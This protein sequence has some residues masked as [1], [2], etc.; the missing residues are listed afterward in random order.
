MTAALNTNEGQ[1]LIVDTQKKPSL[2]ERFVKK[3]GRTYTVIYN[4][5]EHLWNY[6]GKIGAISRQVISASTQSATIT[7]ITSGKIVKHAPKITAALRTLSI[8]SVPFS[9]VSLKNLT[10]KLF[11]HIR[12]RDAEEL[13]LSS[14]SFSIQAADVFDSITTFVNATLSLAAKPTIAIFSTLGIPLGLFMSG[15]GGISRSINIAKSLN[16]YHQLNKHVFHD[17]ESL[18]DESLEALK[19]FLD[20][21]LNATLAEKDKIYRKYSGNQKKADKKIQRLENRKKAA[22]LRA[23]SSEISKKM[24]ELHTLLDSEKIGN[25]ETLKDLTPE[26]IQKSLNEMKSGLKKKTFLN[27]IGTLSNLLT[28]SALIM[29]LVGF[30]TPLPY[31]ILAVSLSLRIGMLLIEDIK[32]SAIAET[33]RE[34]K[35]W[36]AK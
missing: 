12:N 9:L 13:A 1:L 5:A 11:D 4:G 31:I 7:T 14:L 6:V 33:L 10:F 24:R 17:D 3:A 2:L 27:L 21:K 34:L 16:L 15:A 20:N 26:N 32:P 30:V 36:L 29:F 18:N 28:I 25:I 8:I 22:L 23:G 35:N 19:E